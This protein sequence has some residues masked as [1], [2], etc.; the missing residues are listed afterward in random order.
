MED[1]R[2]DRL[3]DFFSKHE[4]K[5]FAQACKTLIGGANT[6]IIEPTLDTSILELERFNTFK[7]AFWDHREEFLSACKRLHIESED[8]CKNTLGFSEKK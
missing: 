8:F 1:T 3:I 6:G 2:I 5:D 4:D 7:Q